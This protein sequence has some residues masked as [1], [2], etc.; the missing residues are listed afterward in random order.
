MVNFG[1]FALFSEAKPV[2]RSGKHPQKVDNLHPVGLLFKLLTSIQQT[3]QLMY[4]FEKSEATRG[5]EL[6]NHK[7]SKGTFFVRI[8][9]TDVFG[10]ADQEKMFHG[11]GYTLTL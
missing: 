10:Y 5:L 11:F 7:S 9:L 4:G 3:S 2:T 1:P 6:T 8:K